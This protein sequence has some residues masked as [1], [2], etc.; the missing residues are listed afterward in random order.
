[1][2]DHTPHLVRRRIVREVLAD[3]VAIACFLVL[4]MVALWAWKH[5]DG[6]APNPP[7]APESMVE[8]EKPG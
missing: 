7:T 3:L 6:L 1:M 4:F 5:R 8:A 2:R